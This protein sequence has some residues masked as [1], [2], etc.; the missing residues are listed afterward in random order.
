LSADV[1]LMPAD[2]GLVAVAPAIPPCL[3]ALLIGMS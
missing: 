3:V 2:G 1:G